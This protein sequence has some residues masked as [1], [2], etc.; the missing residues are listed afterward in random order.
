MIGRDA[1]VA[2]ERRLEP[3]AEARAVDRGDDRRPELLEPVEQRLPVAAQRLRLGS[4]SMLR[5]SSMSAPATQLSGLPLISTTPARIDSSRSRRSSSAANSSRTAAVELVHRL[6]RQVER[7]DGDAV[8]TSV[9]SAERHS[10]V[11]S[12]TLHDHREA[13]SAG[14]AHRHQPELPAAAPQ[15]VAAA[16]S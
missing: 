5:N 15:L 4:V 14:G 7:D 12:F 9:V 6:A 10:R 11:S 3:A 8:A 1:I 13:H 16:S 2:G